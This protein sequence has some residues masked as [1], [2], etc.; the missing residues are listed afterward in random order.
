[1][2][3]RA[4]VSSWKYFST[5]APRVVIAKTTRV[6]VIVR[7]STRPCLIKKSTYSLRMSQLTL[8][9]YMIC[10]S[11]NGPLIANTLR[12]ATWVSNFDL[13]IFESLP[14]QPIVYIYMLC[15][16]VV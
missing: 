2:I 5:V 10:V 7:F 6:F 4:C 14:S 15:S 12:I 11:F 3:G 9:L 13:L 8:A 16:G 1:M